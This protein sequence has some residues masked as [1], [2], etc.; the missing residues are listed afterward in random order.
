MQFGGTFK[1]FFLYVVILC[2]PTVDSFPEN[3][4]CTDVYKEKIV[5]RKYF[6]TLIRKKNCR[7]LSLLRSKNPVF[8]Y[9]LWYFHYHFVISAHLWWRPFWTT[10]ICSTQRSISYFYGLQRHH[11][12]A[13]PRYI[14]INTLVWYTGIVWSYSERAHKKSKKNRLRFGRFPPICKDR[15]GA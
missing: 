4:E 12:S 10:P 9:L 8:V 2:R 5:L 13:W 3:G 1:L 6:C 7:K 14:K 15:F 11:G